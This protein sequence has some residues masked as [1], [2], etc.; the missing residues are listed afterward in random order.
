MSE[1]YH[2][3]ADLKL[4]KEMRKLAPADFD[5]WLT[6]DKIVGM[7]PDRIALYSYA[8]VPHL[9]KPQRRI[10]EAELPRPEDKL[11]ILEQTINRLTAAGYIYIGMDHF[12]RPDDELALAQRGGTLQ[13]NFQGYSTHG[14]CDLLAF[15]I[16]AIGKVGT[17]YSQNVRTL[18]EYYERLDRGVL[19]CFRGIELDAD[20]RVRREVIGALMCGSK[21][22]FGAISS[23]HGVEF[24]DYFATEL[25]ALAPLAAD[26]LVELGP[27]SIVVTPR[28]RLL[29]RTVAMVFDRHLREQRERAK[30]SRVI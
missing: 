28:G 10:A 29:M 27:E 20:D 17:T 21:V 14:D 15:G 25:D 13:R 3:A 24:R 19:P 18:D 30:Y 2:D 9:F 5:A 12:A 7:A 26:G 16:S 8:H 6:L 11:T 4:M 22:D 23:A 1:H